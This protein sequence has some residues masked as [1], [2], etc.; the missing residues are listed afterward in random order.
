MA[1]SLA[2]RV[3]SRGR[4]VLA[5]ATVASLFGCAAPLLP[6]LRRDEPPRFVVTPPAAAGAAKI[7]NITVGRDAAVGSNV[8]AVGGAL[9]GLSC[10]P[11]AVF[12]VPITMGLGA[13]A[14]SGAG[15]VVG[16][17]ASLPA[18]K[19]ERLR[20]RLAEV[21]R[22]HDL[23]QELQDQLVH[24]ARQHWDLQT[25]PQ[26]TLVEARFLELSLVSERGEQV[27]LVLKL[28]VGVK[29]AAAPGPVPAERLFVCAPV[30]ASLA[31]W[32]DPGSDYVDLTVQ[33]CLQQLAAQIVAEL[34]RS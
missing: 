18:E 28:G 9:W 23:A 11:F 32:L 33:A 34:A 22:T 4:T 10:G 2:H 24:R 19:A 12:C 8:G 29:R 3:L 5:V 17:S 30:P 13:M 7:Q 25:E 14:G 6:P 1:A 20:A 27:G 31:V 26:G 21:G 16:L 15:A